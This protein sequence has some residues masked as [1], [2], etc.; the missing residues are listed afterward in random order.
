M[1][2][3]DR[4]G[5]QPREATT[6]RASWGITLVA[7]LMAAP[8]ARA[9]DAAAGENVFRK[10]LPC[11][12][13]GAAAKNKVGPQLNGLE[14]RQAGTVPGYSYSTANKNSR[15]VWGQQTFKSYIRDPRARVPGTKMVFPGI[16]NEKEINDLWA[17]LSQ[18]TPDGG[19]K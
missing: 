12:D 17:Y 1:A 3:T 5:E 2:G 19:R 15:I 16:K 7:A 18:F 13:V 4:D 14:G 11:H 8:A 6:M 10:C 9:Q